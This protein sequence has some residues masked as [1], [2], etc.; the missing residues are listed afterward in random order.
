MSY[1]SRIHRK[2]GDKLNP[3]LA[4]HEKQSSKELTLAS[5]PTTAGLDPCIAVMV[6]RISRRPL[7]YISSLMTSCV[8][9]AH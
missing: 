2:I 6:C 3:I 5:Y 9:R 8:L 7:V 4:N 1:I